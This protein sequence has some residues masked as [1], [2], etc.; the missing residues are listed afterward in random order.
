MAHPRCLAYSPARALHRVLVSDLSSV[1]STPSLGRH[2]SIYY[3]F[4]PRLFFSSS[5]AL[6]APKLPSSI[7]LI[8]IAAAP[9][10]TPQ[11]QH[12]RT[13][14]T[15]PVLH[16]PEAYR[17]RLTNDKIPYKWVRIAAPPPDSSLSPP[18]RIESVLR[19]LDPKTHT[20]VM[21]AP[22]PHQP[23]TLETHEPHAAVCR[24]IDNAAAEA[25]AAEAEKQARRKAV[26][27]KELELSWSIAGHDLQHKL[28]RLREFLEKGLNVEIIMAK[29]K[30]GR[31]ATV[32]EAE[33]VVAQVREAVASVDGAKESRKMDG[34]V[35]GLARLFFEGPS[36]KKR[37][38]KKQEQEQAQAQAQA[39]GQGGE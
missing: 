2:A 13:L 26:D 1:I 3:L 22:P 31:K 20:L 7:P 27:T 5:S 4:P 16:A 37:R 25:A 38:R 29:K 10:P 34:D 18:Q 9:P 19:S 11:Q 17:K 24:I 12:V 6:L 14:T 28:R 32:E 33:R 8:P 15:S 21:V 39:Q 35:G 30:G 36:E 23:H